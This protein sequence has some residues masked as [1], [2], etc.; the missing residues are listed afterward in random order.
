M[1]QRSSAASTDLPSRESG[2]SS[3]S[4]ARPASDFWR[5][6]S[7]GSIIL[8]SAFTGSFTSKTMSPAMR[9]FSK[10]K[11]RTSRTPGSVSLLD[12]S[13]TLR[14]AFHFDSPGDF[15]ADNLY[16]PPSAG[17]SYAVAS[18]VPTPQLMTLAPCS[19]IDSIVYS[20]KSFESTMPQSV[21]P[22]ASRRSR[23]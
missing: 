11:R 10:K 9:P 13:V 4:L 22:A 12:I 6:K 14:R 20:S 1:A 3:V 17:W 15:V 5:S 8:S 19:R 21:R 7:D 16:T 2:R 23:A 18:F